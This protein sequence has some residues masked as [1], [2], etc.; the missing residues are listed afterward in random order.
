MKKWINLFS[1][2]SHKKETVNAP[3]LEKGIA[4]FDEKVSAPA[5]FY[6]DEQKG[7]FLAKEVIDWNILYDY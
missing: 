1:I 4:Y 3:V 6:Y 2:G 7:I 5:I